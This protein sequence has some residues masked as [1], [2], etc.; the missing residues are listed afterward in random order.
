MCELN[1]MSNKSANGRI[2]YGQY[3]TADILLFLL[4]MCV[5]EAINVFA[6]RSWFPGMMFTVSV[7]LLVTLIVLVRWNWFGLLFPVAD[8]L[9]YCWMNGA[10]AWQFGVYAI[11]NAFVALV[12]LFFLAVP[13]EKVTAHW[14]LTCI[15]AAIAF[16]LLLLGRSVVAACFGE[17]FVNTLKATAVGEALNLAF[18][19]IGLLVVRRF[20]GMFCDQKQ[21]LLKVAKERD[22]LKRADEYRWDGY[23]ELN[24]DDL[25]ALA[26]ID[27]YDTA[28]KFNKRGLQRL[29]EE[30][31]HEEPPEEGD[32]D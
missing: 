32:G 9:I 25:K 29:K 23:T 18:A 1:D 7:M 19:I 24:E 10:A 21:Y 20:D 27:E 2:S 13:K 28:V 11:G 8:G 26:A 3:K 31:G 15:Y 30:D 4:I 6:I 12:W 22:T 14:W 16:V 17:S 5:C